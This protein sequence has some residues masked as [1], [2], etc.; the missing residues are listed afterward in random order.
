MTARSQR[1]AFSHDFTTVTAMRSL[2]SHSQSAVDVP[3]PTPMHTS[4]TDDDQKSNGKG[5]LDDPEVILEFW[6]IEDAHVDGE[7]GCNPRKF[8]PKESTTKA[9]D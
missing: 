4:V 5:K 2:T 8:R 9:Q 3:P 6:I 7:N 1:Q